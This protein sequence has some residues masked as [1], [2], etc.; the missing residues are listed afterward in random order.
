MVLQPFQ[1]EWRQGY[2]G[3]ARDD[4]SFLQAQ[5]PSGHLR[6]QRW[7]GDR[8]ALGLLQTQAAHGLDN[9]LPRAGES[10]AIFGHARCSKTDGS[11][12]AGAR[13]V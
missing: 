8:S 4:Q 3:K 10:G 7:A 9:L 11:S 12:S 13:V 2:F 6:G 5:L 1:L